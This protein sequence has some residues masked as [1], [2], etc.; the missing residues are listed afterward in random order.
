MKYEI[1]EKQFDLFKKE[2][3]K[4]QKEFGLINYHLEVVLDGFMTAEFFACCELDYRAKSARITM[5]DTWNIKPTKK[6]IKR[7]ALHEV[8]E[9]LLGRMNDLAFDRFVCADNLEEAK[10]HVIRVLESTLLK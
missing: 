9:L 10:H 4:W 7:Y 6:L 3:F 5:N 1:T 2:V 8:L